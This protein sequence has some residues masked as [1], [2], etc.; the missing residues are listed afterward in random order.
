MPSLLITVDAVRQ[1]HLGQFG[2]HRDTMPALDR[3][4]ADGTTFPNAFSNAPYTRM[5][6]PSFHTSQ[7]RG[8][9]LIGES[10][11]IAEALSD[12]GAHTACLGTLTG[13]KDNEG[14][15]VFDEYADLGRDEFYEQANHSPVLDAAKRAVEPVVSVSR[16]L[17]EAAES[18]HDRLFSTHEFKGYTSAERMTDEVIDWLREAPDDFFLWV[19][20][21]EGHR[22]YGVHDPDPEYLDEQPDDE[23]IMELMETAG[24]APD[25]VTMG[26]NRL[27]EDLYDSDL[28]YCSEHLD[29]LFDFM[30]SAG[31]WAETDIYFTSDHGEEFY[32]HGMY[33]H[34]NLPYDELINVPLFTKLA[35][36]PGGETIAA[37]R[38]LLDLAP[39]ICREHGLD[40]DDLP[41]LGTNLFEGGDRKVIT[42]GS[43]AIDDRAVVGG[44]WDGWKYIRD[45]DRRH[46]FDLEADPDERADLAD[47]RPGVVDEFEA[48]I[49]D[50]LFRTESLGTRDPDDAAD[51]EQLA[52]LGYMEV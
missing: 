2:Y 12:A 46:L 14:A 16:P 22:P 42:T 32:D 24:T 17:Y 10:P 20:Y 49:P 48:E 18:V 36:R 43:A 9:E 23:T 52:A 31:L 28:R 11:T 41:F 40:T 44:R 47:D 50:P 35:S 13:F 30:Q 29:R 34:R 8:H 37:D 7:Y 38:E 33:F 51:E 19:H 3:L 25:D 21:M 5:S 39:T 1:S 45:G 15:L 26:Q 6:I 4:A 27:I